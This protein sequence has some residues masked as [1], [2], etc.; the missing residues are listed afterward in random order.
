MKIKSLF[1]NLPVSDLK[2][3][4]QFWETLGFAFNENFSDENAACLILKPDMMHVMLIT[5]GLFS[6]FTNRAI[7]DPTVTQVLNALEVD[8][9]QEVDT[10]VQIAL[11]NGATRYKESA[12]HGWMY[13]DSFAD[14]DGHQWEIL[15]TDPS[16]IPS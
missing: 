13:Y 6:T 1:V 11:Q 8:S 12:D 14:P 3:S 9:R 4:R 2:K 16:Q 15:Y 7:A 10:L 5:H